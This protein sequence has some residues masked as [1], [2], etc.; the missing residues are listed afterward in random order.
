MGS[1]RTVDETSTL[2][3]AGGNAI[4]MT[5]AIFAGEMTRA[6]EEGARNPAARRV[7]RRA[8]GRGRGQVVAHDVTP[9]RE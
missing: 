6:Y 7:A 9:A 3:A 1:S 8:I 2:G 4:V 5:A